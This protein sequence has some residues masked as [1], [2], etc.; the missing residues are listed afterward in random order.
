MSVSLT[1]RGQIL[2]PTSP[3]HPPTQT[4]APSSTPGDDARG[5]LLRSNGNN[6]AQ[7]LDPP[8]PAVAPLT[9]RPEVQLGYSATLRLPGKQVRVKPQVSKCAVCVGSPS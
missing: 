8:E 7:P 9:S 1:E 6:K 5:R 3:H 2:M 4:H